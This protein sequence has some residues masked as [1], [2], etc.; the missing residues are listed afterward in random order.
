MCVS[1]VLSPSVLLS[2]FGSHRRI[3]CLSRAGSWEGCHGEALQGLEAPVGCSEGRRRQYENKTLRVINSTKRSDGGCNPCDA[4]GM[5]LAVVHTSLCRLRSSHGVH[6]GQ[7]PPRK[8][9]LSHGVC[10][11]HGAEGPGTGRGTQ[12]SR[13]KAGL[14][15][16]N[17]AASKQRTGADAAPGK[18]FRKESCLYSSFCRP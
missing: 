17:T 13:A 3:R 14:R 9:Q 7:L 8:R 1:A 2:A 11:S 4:P 12:P 6:G 16:W 15:E 5:Q 18:V 10:S